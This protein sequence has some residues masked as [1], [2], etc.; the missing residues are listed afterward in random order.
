MWR[1]N[2]E[3]VIGIKILVVYDM[4]EPRYIT[5]P[6]FILN[7]CGMTVIRDVKLAFYVELI[8][9]EYLSS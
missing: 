4:E 7:Y 6:C 3:E 9:S 1:F 5:S 8:P 2:P